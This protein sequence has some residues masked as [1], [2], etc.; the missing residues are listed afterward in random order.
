M[1]LANLKSAYNSIIIGSRG[2]RCKNILKVIIGWE[3]T[4]VVR[5]DHGPPPY[6]T[7]HIGPLA[8]HVTLQ[9][10]GMLCF[11]VQ[12]PFVQFILLSPARL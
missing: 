1:R 3:A 12:R 10:V 6:L 5:F 8:F 2:L 4:D 7:L 9:A 11:C